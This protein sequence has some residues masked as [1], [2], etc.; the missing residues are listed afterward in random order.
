MD[1]GSA[2]GHDAQT[3]NHFRF[4]AGLTCRRLHGDGDGIGDWIDQPLS[5]HRLRSE[6]AEL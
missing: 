6:R 1:D 5:A 3:V 2:G 4:W